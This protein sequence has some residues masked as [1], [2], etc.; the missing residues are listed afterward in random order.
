MIRICFSLNDDEFLQLGA[1]VWGSAAWNVTP[2]NDSIKSL[3]D[4]IRIQV[5]KKATPGQ[6][7][8]LDKITAALQ[9]VFGADT[10]DREMIRDGFNTLMEQATEKLQE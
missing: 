10:V 6:I 5:E 2:G 8:H 1:M 7:I 3:F 4:K 9:E